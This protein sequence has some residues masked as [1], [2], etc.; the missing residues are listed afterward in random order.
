[1]FLWRANSVQHGNYIFFFVH[2]WLSLVSLMYFWDPFVYKVQRYINISFLLMDK[3][4][5]NLRR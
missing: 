1:M 4:A 5:K 3:L 2:R